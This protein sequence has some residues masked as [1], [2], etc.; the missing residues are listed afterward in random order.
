VARSRTAWVAMGLV[1][2]TSVLGVLAAAV[3]GPWTISNRFGLW[4]PAQPGAGTLTPRAEP[5]GYPSRPPVG[6]PSPLPAWLITAL[7]VLA[8]VTLAL[9]AAVVLW[10]LLAGRLR[11]A[12]RPNPAEPGIPG[13]VYPDRPVV[14]LGLATALEVLLATAD[15]TDAVLAAWV[16]LEAAAERSGVPRKPSDTP[17]EFTARVL[18]GTPADTEAVQTLLELYLRARFARRGLNAG[19]FARARDCLTSLAASWADFDAPVGGP[20]PS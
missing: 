14:Q 17:T 3:A 6:P 10:R 4:G 1:V 16:H 11:A 9:L 18:T 8:V 5:T 13:E 2:A 20:E 15:P 19:D 7:W 12:R